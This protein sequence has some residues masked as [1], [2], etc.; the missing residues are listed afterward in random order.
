MPIDEL[1]LSE[2]RDYFSHKPVLKAW[3]FGSQAREDNVSSSDYDILLELDYDQLIGLEFVN[4]KLE[5]E[6]L[7]KSK[8]D[9]VTLAGISKYILPAVEKE[10]K[11]I[12]ER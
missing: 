4:M 7:L 6:E 2:M 10:R 12:Y 9:L 1:K 8:V 11:L 5:L 3:L